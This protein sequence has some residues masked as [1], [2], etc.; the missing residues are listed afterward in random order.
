MSK[1]L[2]AKASI[3]IKVPAHRVWEALVD[4]KTIQKY[5]FGAQVVSEWRE[6]SSII[7]KGE[8]QGKPFED[9]GKILQMK[10]GHFIQ[11]SHFSPMSGMPDRP[12][13]YHI[14]TIELSPD[15]TQTQVTLTQDHNASEEERAHSETNW[16]MML[17]SLKKFLEQP[18]VYTPEQMPK[19]N[20]ALEKFA[21]L[22]GNWK[23]EAIMGDLKQQGR[24]SFEWGDRG[25]FLV[26]RWDFA[27]EEMP[28]AATW[29]IG[30][31]ESS[32]YCSV[33]YYDSRSVSR[34]LNMSLEDGIWKMWRN[35]PEFSQRFTGKISPDGN[36]I[37]VYLE[38]SFDIVNWM[39]DFDLVYTRI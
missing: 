5:M 6:G 2:M 9:R 20:P 32:Q 24:A 26:E 7:W 15:G 31:D 8:W 39:H 34:V 13:N 16:K 11:Y 28:P 38:K 10:P 22:V 1:G 14:V 29:I 18:H 37:N 33:L 30:S 36:T 17:S 3:N 23:V 35:E 12:E 25:G 4:P 21:I 19:S 27:P